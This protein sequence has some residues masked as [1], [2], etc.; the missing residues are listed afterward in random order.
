M[1]LGSY[2]EIINYVDDTVQAGAYYQRLGSSEVTTDVYTDGRYHLRVVQGTGINPTLRYYGCDIEAL[3][4]K[5]LYITDG[6]LTSPQGVTIEVTADAPPLS[7]PHDDVMLAPDTS[8]LGKFGEFTIFVDDLPAER[9][10][11]EQCGFASDGVQPGGYRWGIW[12]DNMML[13]GIHETDT[14]DP[15]TITHFDPNMQAT[16]DALKAEE[17]ELK[18]LDD[19][20][21]KT[22][23]THTT[24]INPHGIQF[25]LFTG[26]ISKE[27]P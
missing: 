5:G 13:I 9:A 27:N 22:V 7:L 24:L 10:F 2:V 8:R 18:P 17:F 21:D 20:P 26:D 6:K 23:L 3:S 4:A 16:N 25:F 1:T 12:T 15:F 11:W 19:L 14:S